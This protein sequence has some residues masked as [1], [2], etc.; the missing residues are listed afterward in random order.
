MLLRCTL[1]PLGLFMKKVMELLTLNEE[2]RYSDHTKWGCS[3]SVFDI[4]SGIIAD[5]SAL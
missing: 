4:S 3:A 1:F 5:P 2:L